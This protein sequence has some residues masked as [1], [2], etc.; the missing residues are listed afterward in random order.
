MEVEIWKQIL[1]INGRIFL[2]EKS[3]TSLQL[4]V[5]LIDFTKP[6]NFTLLHDI[7]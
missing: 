4:I 1:D 3:N 5:D 2:A 7:Q 6:Y